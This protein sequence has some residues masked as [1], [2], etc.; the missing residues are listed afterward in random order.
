MASKRS[1]SPFERIQLF[2]PVSAYQGRSSPT[3]SPNI[4]GGERSP[5]ERP[6]NRFLT[7]SAR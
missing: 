1:E 3:R 6:K 4:A 7:L 2:A 5:R